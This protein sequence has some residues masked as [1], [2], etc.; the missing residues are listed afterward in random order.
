MTLQPVLPAVPTLFETKQLQS[1]ISPN[2]FT[3]QEAGIY[4]NAKS[5]NFW[6][7]VFFPKHSDSTLKH[8]GKAISIDFSEKHPTELHGNS[9]RIR[10][11]PYNVSKVGLHDQLL[12]K[13]PLFAPYWFSDSFR[14]IFVFPC[15]ILTKCWIYFSTS[16]F[17]Q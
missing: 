9:D 1:A 12:N 5:T 10:F 4:S 11:Q 3:A 13:A 8:L 14:A 17:L 6:N 2:S 7:R 15:N 16:L